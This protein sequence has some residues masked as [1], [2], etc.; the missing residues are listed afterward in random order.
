MSSSSRNSARYLAQW[1]KNKR[2]SIY[3]FSSCKSYLP[4]SELC[5]KSCIKCLSITLPPFER[6]S[7][8]TCKCIRYIWEFY[9]A[10][11]RKILKTICNVSDYKNMILQKNKEVL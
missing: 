2:L 3:S 9:E 8:K 4:S 5:N 7:A 11:V 6:I 10:Y 1:A